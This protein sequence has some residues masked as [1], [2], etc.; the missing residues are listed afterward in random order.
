MTKTAFLTLMLG[1]V[2]T[3]PAFAETKEKAA[4]AAEKKAKAVE[5]KPEKD[6]PV[7]EWMTAENK[8]IDTLNKPG[9][10]SF[11]ILRNKH[12][13]IRTVR[14]VER[15]VGSA[16]AACGK[17]N[18]DMKEAM[19]TRFKD[20]KHAIDPILVD[21]DKFLK[22]E[23]EEQQ[24]VY[25]ND[26]RHVLA[27]NDKAFDYTES[28]VKKEVV[29]DKKACEKLLDSMDRTEDKLVNLLQDIL[30]PENVVRERVKNNG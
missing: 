21:A 26:F 13:V 8:L 14:V 19:D 1:V 23:I 5:V 12:S 9:K 7:N 29:T 4:P 2:L 3:T 11:L 10:E 6:N 28:M 18:P 20:W 24:L 16:V 25:P 27:L 15:D 30:V 22:K 17:N